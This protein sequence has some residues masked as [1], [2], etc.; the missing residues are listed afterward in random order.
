MLRN[1]SDLKGAWEKVRLNSEE[2][3]GITLETLKYLI[4]MYAGREIP[5]I[6]SG[7]LMGGLRELLDKF[8]SLGELGQDDQEKLYCLVFSLNL[9]SGFTYDNGATVPIVFLNLRE[10]LSPQGSLMLVNSE[11][12]L[13]ASLLDFARSKIDIDL[14]KKYLEEIDKYNTRVEGLKKL[15]SEVEKMDEELRKRE[16]AYN[17]V[18]LYEGFNSMRE[19][20]QGELDK[21]NTLVKWLGIA[22]VAPLLVKLLGALLPGGD[23]LNVPLLITI[24]GLELILIYFFRIALHSANSIKAQLLQI[25]LRRTLC[26]FIQSYADY[27]KKIKEGNPAALDKFETL[28]FSGLVMQDDKLP[29]TFDGLEPIQKILERRN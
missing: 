7:S 17:F 19:A 27:S 14:V 25:D 2:M 18:G 5:Q 1:Y 13:V 8:G 9:A 16:V 12:R 10:K 3:Q 23:E 28:I 20:K 26:S 6:F 15:S 21:Q 11:M 24:G 22:V 4:A 29:S